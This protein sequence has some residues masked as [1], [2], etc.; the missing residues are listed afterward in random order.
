M[1]QAEAN[2]LVTWGRHW[3]ANMWIGD[4]QDRRDELIAH[5][6]SELGGLGF[7]LA[8]RASFSACGPGACVVRNDA[9]RRG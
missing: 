2:I 3:F 1:S 5:V 6:N 9:D 4:Q 8:W 7:E